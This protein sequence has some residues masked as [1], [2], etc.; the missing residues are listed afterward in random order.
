[1]PNNAFRSASVVLT[2]LWLVFCRFTPTGKGAG[3]GFKPNIRC[4]SSNDD[5]ADVE[6]AVA[7]L[8][9]HVEAL[10]EPVN[11]AKFNES[12]PQ[13]AEPVAELDVDVETSNW[14][15]CA[16]AAS[17]TLGSDIAMFSTL[18]MSRFDDEDCVKLLE[19]LVEFP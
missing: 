13:F 4:A 10:V 18:F 12:A 19:E 14:L 15:I 16:T 9:P 6:P 7:P 5:D 8:A 2:E 3:T 11:A 17:D 1:M